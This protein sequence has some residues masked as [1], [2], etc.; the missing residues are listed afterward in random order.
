MTLLFWAWFV[1]LVIAELAVALF[2]G[3]C[4]ASGH[5]QEPKP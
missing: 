4:I 2:I 5:P 1:G 3:Q